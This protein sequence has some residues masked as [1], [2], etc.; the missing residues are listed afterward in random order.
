MTKPLIHHT[1]RPR[2]RR[3]AKTLPIPPRR[4]VHLHL[5]RIPTVHLRARRRRIPTTALPIIHHRPKLVQTTNPTQTPRPRARS[6]RRPGPRPRPRTRRRPKSRSRSRSGSRS[7]HPPQLHRL[8]YIR[9]MIRRRR[10]NNRRLKPDDVRHSAGRLRRV[11][12]DPH[13]HPVCAH[14]AFRV[15]DDGEGAFAVWVGACE[16]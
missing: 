14:V 8:P 3:I 4:T 13:A 12:L 15:G 5:L 10:H 1:I 11:V 9:L 6:R 16:G 7:R 2:T